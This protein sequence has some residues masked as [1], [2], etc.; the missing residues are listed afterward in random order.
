MQETSDTMKLNI[1]TRGK[2]QWIKIMIAKHQWNY[3]TKHANYE[4][5]TM[6]YNR[7]SKNTSETIKLSIPTMITVVCITIMIM[8]ETRDTMKLNIPTR[9]KY[10]ELQSW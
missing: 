2:V 8:Q 4:N 3:E 7:D 1:P 10:N 5:S 6:N 9:G